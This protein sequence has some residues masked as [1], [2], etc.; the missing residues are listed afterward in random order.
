MCSENMDQNLDIRWKTFPEQLVKLFS[1]LGRD[2]NFTDVTLVSDD[3][4]QTQAHKVV[5]SACSPVLRNL[6]VNNRHSHPL[7][8]LRGI[9]QIELLAV[10]EFM[11]FGQTK[12]TIRRV[13]K[14]LDVA[15]DLELKEVN[16]HTDSI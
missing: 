8:Y 5:L 10:L 9:Q 2:G 13:K 11:Y 4:I 1:N 15:K 7:V 3:Q 16:E 12:V 6:L 14:F